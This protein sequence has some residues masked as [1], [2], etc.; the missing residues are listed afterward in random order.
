M[1]PTL[2]LLF[3]SFLVADALRAQTPSDPRITQWRV[4]SSVHYARIYPTEAAR[5]AGASVTTWSRGQGV[6][7]LPTYAGVQQV[8]YSDTWVYVRSSG[9]GYH[10]MGPWYLNA[11][12]T[13]LFPNY[14]A[15]TGVLYRV[16]RSP[17]A[18]TTP[19]LTGGGPIG[20]FVDGV[21]LFDN[22]DTFS[23]SAAN[24]S[25]AE[26]VNG[27]RGDGVWNRDA[28]VNEGV[29]FDAAFAHQAGSTYHYHA[30]T[31]ALRHLLDDH[32]EYLAATGTY[33][34]S[35]DAPTRHSPILAWAADGY[36]LYGPYG[37]AS[38]TDASSGVRRMI[39]GYVKRDG[40]AGTKALAT[41]GRT[42]LPAWAA[43]AQGR[44]ANLEAALHGPAVDAT[45]LLGRYLEDYDY[46]GDLGRT[47]G[48]D[49]DLDVS[50]GRFCVTPE[51]P[52][53]TYAYFTAIEVNGTPRFPYNLGRWYHGTPSGGSV[54]TIAETVREYVRGGQARPIVVKAE[55]AASGVTLSW[56]SVEGG[57]YAIAT[58]GDGAT[59]TTLAENLPSG[60]GTTNFTTVTR[61]AY[62]RVTLTAVASFDTDGTGGLTGVGGQGTAQAAQVGSSGTV[63]LV[64]LSTRVQVGGTAGSPIAGFVIEGTGIQRVLLRAVGPT[65]ATFAVPGTL[66]DPQLTLYSGGTVVASNDDWSATGGGTSLAATFTSAGAFALP[67]GSKDAALVAEL[68]PGAYTAVVS[69]AT[70]TTGTALVELYVL[71]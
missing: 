12:R 47:Q 52:Q 22:R 11:A 21:A 36:P 3:V 9:L 55:S 14:P 17:V 67:T 62:Y 45:Y 64:N 44:S 37:Y 68:A 69:G 30:N 51:F 65:L 60:G 10:V 66:S 27:L 13:Q 6:Q 31:P 50:N 71:P 39:S 24:K 46:L 40:T 26:P 33:V 25:D 28:Y 1:K 20:L 4:E 58:S 18:A 32:V 42:T 48:V 34:E 49:F 54:G 43:R 5:A 41:T 15:N 23:Y 16:P 53:G 56:T 29:T 61:A 7:P 70:G 8:S 59:F 57:T 19:V 2:F 38:A 63:R 35:T